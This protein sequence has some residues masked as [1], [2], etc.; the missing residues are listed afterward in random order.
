MVHE[1]FE[2]ELVRGSQP[3]RMLKVDKGKNLER[4]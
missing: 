1:V 3:Q 2:I 4:R